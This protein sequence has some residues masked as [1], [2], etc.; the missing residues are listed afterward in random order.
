MKFIVFASLL[1]LTACQAISAQP[2]VTQTLQADD[3]NGS[4]S[5]QALLQQF[6][7][8]AKEYA[9]YKVSS[10]DV[11]QMQSLQGL[12]LIVLFGSWCHD[13]EREVPRLLKLLDQ[14]A[15]QLNTLQLEAVDQNKIHP[16]NLHQTYNLQYT[17][18]IIVLDNGEEIGRIVERPTA[19]LAD[20]LAQIV[21]SNTR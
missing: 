4:I 20:D 3:T 14:S 2:E 21:L 10:K 11:Y 12:S 1:S 16:Q 7:V 5:A 19:S 18:T 9:A 17:S 13:S 6:P 8:F 15:V